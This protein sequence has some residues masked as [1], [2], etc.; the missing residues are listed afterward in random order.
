MEQYVTSAGSLSLLLL[1]TSYS[2]TQG[3]F[4]SSQLH[5]IFL[6]ASVNYNFYHYIGPQI[7][8]FSTTGQVQILMHLLLLIRHSINIFKHPYHTISATTPFLVFCMDGEE[9]G[10]DR[11]TTSY[12]LCLRLWNCL[13]TKK[14]NMLYL[15][16]TMV[17]AKKPM[18]SKNLQE[19]LCTRGQL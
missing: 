14:K 11:A 5:L 13:A 3:T 6:G 17:R 4:P 7:R 2:L 10:G 1:Q 16:K 8:V 12:N 18:S 15:H 9:Q 19:T